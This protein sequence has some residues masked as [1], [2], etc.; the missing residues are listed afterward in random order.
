M[1]LVIGL[2]HLHIGYWVGPNKDP[3]EENLIV[4]ILNNTGYYLINDKDVRYRYLFFQS[5]HIYYILQVQ[6][7]F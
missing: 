7:G 3:H 5:R 4:K 1:L 2:I 6:V